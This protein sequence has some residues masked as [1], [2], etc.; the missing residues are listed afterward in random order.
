MGRRIRLLKEDIR[1]KRIVKCRALMFNG[2]SPLSNLYLFYMLS[3]Q[4][5]DMLN[6]T[7]KI[8]TVEIFIC[9]FYHI[10][11]YVIKVEIS[12]KLMRG[13]YRLTYND[14]YFLLCVFYYSS[15]LNNYE[16]F[17]LYFYFTFYVFS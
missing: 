6:F 12:A 2:F 9:D 7:D 10:F 14:W 17:N 16:N 5:A 11:F 3:Y 13:T 15:F 4:I 8:K 1:E